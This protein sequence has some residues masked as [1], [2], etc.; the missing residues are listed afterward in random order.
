MSA[1]RNAMMKLRHEMMKCIDPNRMSVPGYAP[2]I[3]KWDKII[4]EAETE[5]A[6]ELKPYRDGI[7]AVL[8]TVEREKQRA[9]A[10]LKNFPE[11]EDARMYHRACAQSHQAGRILSNVRYAFKNAGLPVAT[12]SGEPK[13]LK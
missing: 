8:G 13:L 3:E 2:Y 11:H 7:E 4:E 6:K 5:L 10:A 12:V 9:D 1:I